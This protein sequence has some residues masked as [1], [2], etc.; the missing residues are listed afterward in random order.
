MTLSR[1]AALSIPGRG[2]LPGQV[3][4]DPRVAA[5][6]NPADHRERRI[7]GRLE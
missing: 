3:M 4:A 6:S 2:L 7:E 1:V 5:T